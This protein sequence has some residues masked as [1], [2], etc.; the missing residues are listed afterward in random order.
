MT[1][2]LSTTQHRNY[3]G[4]GMI[5]TEEKNA[6]LI[7][8]HV[9]YYYHG[10]CIKELVPSHQPIVGSILTVSSSKYIKNIPVI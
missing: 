4:H 2:R 9:G 5:C 3:T 10:S 7:V 6:E 1:E 8:H